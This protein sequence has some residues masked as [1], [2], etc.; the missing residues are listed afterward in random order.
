VAQTPL[1][2]TV[3]LE[4]ILVLMGVTVLVA[5]LVY[6]GTRPMDP[7]RRGVFTQGTT[8]ANMVF[9]GLPVIVNAFGESVLGPAAV[10]I[11]FMVLASS[12]ISV[13]V[14]VLPYQDPSSRTVRWWVGTALK[15]LQNPLVIGSL[16]GIACSALHLVLPQPIDRALEL[17]G[18]LAMPLAL[19]SLGAD[20][21]LVQLRSELMSTILV[22]MVKLVLLPGLVYLCLQHLGYAGPELGYPVLLAATPTAVVSVVMA[23][24]MRGDPRLAGAIVVGTTLY[25]MATISGWLLFLGQVS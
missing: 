7:A 12:L 21:N 2:Q 9:V 22:G 5:V 19:L 16:A 4:V 18:S 24:E 20:L 17:L 14:L 25:S 23:Q 10:V 8:R 3:A 6:L 13:V 15:I 11:G 1:E